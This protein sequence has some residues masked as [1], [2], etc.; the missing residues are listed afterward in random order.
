M[1]NPSPLPPEHSDRPPQPLGNPPAKAEMR[2]K[3]YLASGLLVALIFT[4]IVMYRTPEPGPSTI[5]APET[6]TSTDGLVNMDQFQFV[7]ATKI[8]RNS[9]QRLFFKYPAY[10]ELTAKTASGDQ[11]EFDTLICAGPKPGTGYANGE[12]CNTTEYTPYIEIVMKDGAPF[13]DIVRMQSMQSGIEYQNGQ[14]QARALIQ[15]F[16]PST[17]KKKGTF[18]TNPFP[19]NDTPAGE[20]YESTSSST[21]P[22]YIA[23]ATSEQYGADYFF[24]LRDPTKLDDFKRVIGSIT[25]SFPALGVI[26]DLTTKEKKTAE[27]PMPASSIKMH[28]YHN[29]MLL[30]SRGS[31]LRLFDSELRGNALV[32]LGKYFGTSTWQ[33]SIISAAFD[34]T[35]PGDVVVVVT[36][37][38]GR[39]KLFKGSITE[40]TMEAVAEENLG[41]MPYKVF[42]PSGGKV[43]VGIGYG[44]AGCVSQSYRVV[45]IA[46]KTATTSYHHGW[47][48]DDPMTERKYVVANTRDGRMVYG[49][50]W[51]ATEGRFVLAAHDNFTNAEKTIAPIGAEYPDALQAQT[52]MVGDTLLRFYS[53]GMPLAYDI[54]SGALTRIP[55]NSVLAKPLPILQWRQ[56]PNAGAAGFLSE[57]YETPPSFVY[58]ATGEVTRLPIAQDHYYDSWLVADNH[59]YGWE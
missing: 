49:V 24:V 30:V 2:W 32:D 50:R 37:G 28:D 21:H 59:F 33:G 7:E 19:Q 8:Y 47:C 16:S 52:G 41:L 18:T 22:E 31:E 38:A 43:V 6:A 3:T 57:N 55:A 1:E 58:R 36:G 40:G 10:M 25:T 54:E 5:I 14:L 26:Y 35:R 56:L 13:I 45:D 11:Y 42:R 15:F 34:P 51:D 39:G 27:M 23:F 44:D 53:F 46:S 12:S 48:E 17:F 20:Y 29:G 9:A 4:G